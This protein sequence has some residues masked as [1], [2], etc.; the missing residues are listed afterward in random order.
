MS[1]MTS[2]DVTTVAPTSTGE[3]ADFLRDRSEKKVS[4][5]PLGGGTKQ[6]IGRA[7][8][9]EAVNLS[10]EH[11]RTVHHYDPGD[12]TVS[13]GAGMTVETLQ[14]LLAQRGQF[15][16][17]DPMLP[18][19][20]TVGGVLAANAHGPLRSGFGSLRDF[21][22][23]IE[24]ATA[25]GEIAHAG[26]KVVKN[27][28]GYDLMK[29]MIGSYGTLGVIIAAN[30]K[31]FPRPLRTHTFVARFQD[32]D[33]VLG[34]R[35]RLR[36]AL[37]GAFMAMEIISPRAHEYLVEHI[38]R[39]PDEYAPHAPVQPIEHW[40]LALRVSGSDAVMARYR[41]E[42]H[43]E[44]VDEVADDR[45]FWQRL[46]D[47]E[48]AVHRRHR[49]AMVMYVNAPLAEMKTVL[50]AAAEVAPE[51]TMLHAAIG[52]AAAGNLVVAFMPLAVDPP[53]AMAFAHAASAFRGRLGPNVS[54]MVA[55]CPEESKDRFDVW[56]ST[57]TDLALMRA[58]K[59]AM[60]PHNILNRGRFI[61]G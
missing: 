46:S 11:L 44:H 5:V 49:N 43:S 57:P 20:A 58:V 53:S 27:V 25:N 51:H 23:G 28:A 17:F 2:A 39:D 61:V 22:I 30:F 37:G 60:D 32:L 14:D 16:P 47:F 38:A 15:L 12:L 21:C 10:T 31:V 42:L 13:V 36:N 9:A 56:G 18:A 48:I 26:G 3:V 24:F 50:T 29:L 41:S 33:D 45:Q 35:R 40:S 59:A 6:H 1:S 55:R 8:E 7:A 52:R 19:A 34:Y 54:A 4:V